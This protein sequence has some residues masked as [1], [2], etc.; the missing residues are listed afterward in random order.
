MRYNE[1]GCAQKMSSDQTVISSLKFT[2]C[3]VQTNLTAQVL[4][5]NILNDPSKILQSVSNQEG[6]AR[7]VAVKTDDVQISKFV[8]L[9]LLKKL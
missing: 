8:D 7:S 6:R 1:N 2:I 5:P 4:D 9:G 3:R